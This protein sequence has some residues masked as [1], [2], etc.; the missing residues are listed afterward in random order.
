MEF[1][2]MSDLYTMPDPACSAL[3]TIDVQNDFTLPN[4][5]ACIPGTSAVIPMMKSTLEIYRKLHLPIIHVV[6]LYKPDGSNVD[7]CR[8]TLIERGAPIAR[9]SSDGAEIVADLNL[10]QSIKL[11]AGTL[12]KGDPQT[13]SANEWVLYKPRWSAFYQTQLE[14]MLGRLGVNTVV[15]IGCNFPNCPRSTIYDAS[16]RDYRVVVVTD[17]ISGLYDRGLKELQGI[18]VAI[19]TSEQIGRWLSV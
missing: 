19:M 12:L 1:T 8:R 17:A 9:P 4:A 13:V 18:G 2:H 16:N 6:R 3:I 15:I 5:P 10:G 7:A 14:A 11:D